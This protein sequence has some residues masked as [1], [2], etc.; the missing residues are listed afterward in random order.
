M[1]YRSASSIYTTCT[2]QSFRDDVQERNILITVM[3]IELHA[4]G[5]GHRCELIVLRQ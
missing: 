2:R 1:Y 5:D 4:D 3:H